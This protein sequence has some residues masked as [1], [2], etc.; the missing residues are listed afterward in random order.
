MTGRRVLV[1]RPAVFARQM[2]QELVSA[3]YTPVFESFL[4]YEK[5]FNPAPD[6]QGRFVVAI[7][8]Q[9]AAMTVAQDKDL[10]ADFLSAPCFCVG[11]K[12]ARM[13]ELAGFVSPITGEGSGLALAR[14]MTKTLP[15][16]TV[17]HICGADTDP[18][19]ADSLTDVGFDYQGW[20]VYKAHQITTLSNTLKNRIASGGI[21]AVLFYSKRSAQAFVNAVVSSGLSAKLNKILAFALS[22]EVADP[23]A[24][25][26]WKK[27]AIAC[28][29]DQTALVECLNCELPVKGI[30][31]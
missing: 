24:C 11:V 14:L 26:P 1:T 21:D 10:Y 8:S 28:R 13:A 19:F 9:M 15:K 12:T 18:T 5:L 4:D 23:I 7:T 17:L 22:P 25:F 16:Q 2:E 20:P 29:P 31:T 6:I 3:G 30:D 27:L